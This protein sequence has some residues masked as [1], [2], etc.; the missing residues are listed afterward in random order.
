[1]SVSVYILTVC[2]IYSRE[3]NS[4][5]VPMISSTYRHLAISNR[6]FLAATYV[7]FQ[8]IGNQPCII[9]IVYCGHTILANLRRRRS[10]IGVRVFYLCLCVENNEIC[11]LSTS[12]IWTITFSWMPS[13]LWWLFII[14]FLPV[15]VV[16]SLHCKLYI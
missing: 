7:L 16:Q 9:Y 8:A 4:L 5:Y 12:T 13:S 1:M 15:F 3:F 2:Y 11:F 6:L 14:P 10:E